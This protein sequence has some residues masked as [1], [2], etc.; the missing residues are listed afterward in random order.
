[1]NDDEIQPWP[2]LPNFNN[3]QQQHLGTSIIAPASAHNPQNLRHNPG[4]QPGIY[5]SAMYSPAQDFDPQ[6]FTPQNFAPQDFDPQTFNFQNFNHQS[7]THQNFVLQSHHASIA[8]DPKAELAE[9]MKDSG[10][11]YRG[12]IKSYAEHLKIKEAYLDLKN[13]TPGSMQGFPEDDAGQQELV[14][15]LWDAITD[16]SAV[17]HGTRAL[18]TPGVRK[19]KWSQ[20]AGDDDQD[21]D[22]ANAAEANAAGPVLVDS[23]AV[24]HVKGLLSIEKE[25][26]CWDLLH[27]IMEAQLG[28]GSIPSWWAGAKR[29]KPNEYATFRARFDC[30]LAAIKKDKNVV[31]NLTAVDFTKRLAADPQLETRQMEY[32]LGLN[33]KRKKT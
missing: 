26:L 30:V 19:R 13:K 25:I 29:S 28:L 23:V 8:I 12:R 2:A 18:P 7:P 20:P 22:E 16:V 31:K 32:N 24:S 3:H 17:A 5:N 1:M 21:G 10:G 11:Q 14:H 9:Y 27:A 4:Q 15:E 33:S 6:S